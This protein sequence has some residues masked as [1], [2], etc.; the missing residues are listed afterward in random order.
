MQLSLSPR[1][2]S[3][4]SAAKALLATI[5]VAFGFLLIA[6]NVGG[7]TAGDDHG[8]SFDTA[9]LVELGTSVEARIDPG[10]APRK[11]MS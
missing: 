8:N 6:S 3:L 5:S 1:A 4:P 11:R 7:Q 2:H 10:G 9:T